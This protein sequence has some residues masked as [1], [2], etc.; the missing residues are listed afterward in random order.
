MLRAEL[1]KLNRYIPGKPIADVQAEY[2]LG[3]V[4]KLASNENPLGPSPLAVQAAMATLAHL[5]LYPDATAHALRARLSEHWQ[6]AREQL[7]VGD[8]SD[9]LLRL[10]ATMF[11]SPGDEAVM[12]DLTFGVYSHAVHLM[13]GVA[14]K[15]PL[16]E[17]THDLEAMLQLCGAKTKMVFICN[18]NNPTGTSVTHSELANFV[19]RL[20]RNIVV[21]LDEA[22]FE[23][24]N[25]SARADGLELLR[26]GENVVVLRTFSKAYGLAGLRVGYAITTAEYASMLNTVRAPFNVN[27]VAQVAG[28]AA[29]DDHAHLSATLANNSAL[30]T[31]LT[32]DLQALGC[33]V[34]PS[35]ANFVLVNLGVDSRQLY[36]RLLRHGV[37]IRPG[38]EFG[39]PTYGRISI[40][41][42]EQMDACIAALKIELG[43][44][45]TVS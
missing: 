10:L 21:V 33:T 24:D 45:D 26:Q 8:G 25:N 38:Y 5:E 2:G 1:A 34:V 41:T 19:S 4:H 36:P 15:V 16:K 12:A 23:F 43:K 35:Q 9:E 20:P 6:V 29:L 14:V 22:Y 44:L 39:L 11:I 42:L 7:V 3:I 37:V 40:G 27:T 30:R 32:A 31:R 28:R 17:F 18:P 13:G